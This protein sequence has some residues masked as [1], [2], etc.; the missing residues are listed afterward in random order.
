MCVWGGGG[1]GFWFKLK[2]PV[3]GPKHWVF[4]K[5]TKKTKLVLPE[6]IKQRGAQVLKTHSD[7]TEAVLIQ[8]Q[9]G[10]AKRAATIK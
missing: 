1:G 3:F 7:D 10:C 5:F 6:K 4:A 2:N 9:T 8:S